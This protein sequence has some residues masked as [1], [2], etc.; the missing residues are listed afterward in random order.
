MPI[1]L[2]KDCQQKLNGKKQLAELMA[3]NIPGEIF[4]I[5]VLVN[6]MALSKNQPGVREKVLMVFILW[7][8]ALASGQLIGMNHIRVTIHRVLL[9][10]KNIK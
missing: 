5:G 4:T 7:L 10:E 8:A 3:E 2:G 1:G 9:M 6:R